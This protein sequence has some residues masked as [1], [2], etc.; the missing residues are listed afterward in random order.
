MR[1]FPVLYVEVKK[2]LKTEIFFLSVLLQLWCKLAKTRECSAP[3]WSYNSL[4]KLMRAANCVR[5]CCHGVHEDCLPHDKKDSDK[6][7][8]NQH[9]PFF[10][11][12]HH[13]IN[14]FSY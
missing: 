10:A 8:H 1:L 12:L 13:K 3:L 2:C 4:S 5:F 14:D 7:V 9:S 11:I 6:T